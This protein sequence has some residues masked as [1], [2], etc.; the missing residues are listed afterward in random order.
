L[1]EAELAWL[2]THFERT[3]PFLEAALDRWPIKTH[4]KEHIWQAIESG[5]A[6]FWPTANSA[7]VTEI[8]THPTGVRVLHGWLAGGSL[9]EIIKS[10][11]PILDH[12]A[13]EA[14]CD[15]QTVT[16]RRGWLRALS[17]FREAGTTFIRDLRA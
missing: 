6:Q 8:I 12:Y 13:K 5:A 7:I 1:T 9:K 16:G 4:T 3:W 17:S 14:G 11:V 10:T 2:R 15:Y